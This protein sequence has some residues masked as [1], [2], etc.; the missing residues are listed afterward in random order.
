[1]STQT[2]RFV[3]SALLLCASAVP[4]SAQQQKMSDP[5]FGILCDPQKM[6]FDKVPSDLVSACSKLRGRYV[7]A[8]VYGHLKT[9]D[10]EYFLI[11]GLM[12]FRAD[13]AQGTRT[14]A[15][16]ED[17]GLIVA[18]TSSGC[19][20]DLDEYFFPQ[21]INPAKKATPITASP[22]VVNGILQDAFQKYVT[23]FGGKQAFLKLVKRGVAV[24]PV[25]DQLD[26]FAKQPS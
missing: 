14:I 3:A 18:I 16:E 7:A 12:E 17:G 22:A 26:L 9:S 4:A 24:P 1:M 15:P 13:D 5:L 6:H 19:R 23:A 11:S 2:F 21:E 8:W 25:Q 20:V 10:S